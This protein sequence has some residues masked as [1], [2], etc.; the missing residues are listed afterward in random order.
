M[1]TRRGHPAD[2][3]DSSGPVERGPSIQARVYG[4]LYRGGRP[5][6]LARGLNWFWAL[7]HGAG[8]AP[9]YLVTL[10]VR[11]RRSGRTIAFPL[12]LVVVGGGRYLVSMLGENVAWVRNVRADQGRARM[13]HGRHEDVLLV[14]VPIDQRAEILQAYLKI[15]PGARPHLGRGTDAPLTAVAELAGHIPVFRVE[16]RTGG[17][18][19]TSR[20]S[21][22]WFF[23]WLILTSIPFWWA[24]AQVGGW[25]PE[26]V[27]FSLPIS[28]LM[29]FNP[30]WVALALIWHAAGR[31]GVVDWL[32]GM[33]NRRGT[34]SR[35]WAA[36]A[37]VVMPLVLIAEYGLLRASGAY[38][39]MTPV[40]GWQLAAMALVFF[41]FAIGEEAGWQGYAY[42]PLAVRWGPVRAAL[43]LGLMGAVWHLLPFFQTGHSATWVAWQ[44]AQTV[45]ARVIIVWLYERSG[46]HLLS[47]VL[48]H[49]GSNLAVFLFPQW[50][51]G[52]DP[53]ITCLLLTG[54]SLGL[55]AVGGLPERSEPITADLGPASGPR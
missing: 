14:E 13:R 32:R 50:G 46:R 43:L 20:P 27:P 10:E 52:Y 41:V 25:L 18:G 54:L 49:A 11:G 24:G 22:G 44:C 9:D 19:Q 29:A 12:V 33:I 4:W 23:I 16:R 40:D 38:L 35:L 53:F 21:V 15:A 2:H 30:L 37:V 48:F 45:A 39:P 31:A 47:A 7:L 26:S 8:I 51:S 34:R 1:A 6:W 55:V 36:A 5:N 3:S 28:V 42:A 17:A